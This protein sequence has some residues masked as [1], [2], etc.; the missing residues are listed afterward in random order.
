M[1]VSFKVKELS[2]TYKQKDGSC[3][4]KIELPE[5]ELNSG[6]VY[7]ITGVSG[8]GKSTLLECLGLLRQD[9]LAK[10]L[11]LDSYELSQLSSKEQCLVRSSLM[12]YMPQTG[13]LIPYLTIK[14]NLKLQIEVSAAS[15]Y[16]LEGKTLDTKA[17]YHEV[18]VKM[19]KFSM[20]PLLDRYPHELSIGQRQRAVFLKTI[21]HNPKIVFIDEPTSSLDPEHGRIL[22]ESIVSLSR[23]LDM[24][25]L[26]VT[27]DLGLVKDFN[28]KSLYYEMVDTNKGRFV[29][30]ESSLDTQSNQSGE[31]NHDL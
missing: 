23:Q 16:K 13:G 8:C 21:S 17:M 31:D 18:I 1:A 20:D 15:F 24:C 14:E 22:F 11:S 29:A 30:D 9:F 5:L 12:G 10:K 28:L 19:Q 3:G 27:H 2:Y 26:V 4:Y 7:A 25:A 6:D